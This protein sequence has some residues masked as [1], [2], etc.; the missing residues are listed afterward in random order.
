MPEA[1]AGSGVQGEQAIG[2]EVVTEAVRA[3]EVERGGSRGHVKDSA[4]EIERH[5]GPVIGGAAGFP[6]FF[7]PSVVAELARMRNGVKDPS[8]LAVADIKSADVA[9]WRGKRLRV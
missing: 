9:G 4:F 3:I 8:H 5:A 7:R 6:C 2:E 1:L